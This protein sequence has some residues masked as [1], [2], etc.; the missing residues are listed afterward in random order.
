VHNVDDE[1]H[2]AEAKERKDD[3]IDAIPHGAQRGGD[4]GGA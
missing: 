4:D 3:D 1:E 2:A